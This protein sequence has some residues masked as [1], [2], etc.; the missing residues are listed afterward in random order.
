MESLKRSLRSFNW[1]LSLSGSPIFAYKRKAVNYFMKIHALLLVTVF[2]GVFVD[3]AADWAVKSNSSYTVRFM[4]FL[5]NT[6]AF[7]YHLT[8]I[9]I[10]WSIRERLVLLFKQFTNYLTKENYGQISRFTTKLFLHK[11]L[12]ILF[13]KVSYL[14]SVFFKDFDNNWTDI[15]NGMLI[16]TIYRE[17]H[18]PFVGTFSLYL[19]LL[20]V[21]HL[22]ERNM[23]ADLKWNVS[24]RSSRLVYYSIRDCIQL[25]NRVSKQV[26]ILV[27]M[28]F[29]YL[30]LHAVCSICRF[31]LVYFNGQVPTLAKTWAL[32]SIAR[33]IV[34]FSQAVFLVFITHKWTQESQEDLSSLADTIVSV[35][36]IRKWSTVLEEIKVAQEYKYRAFD[37]FNID[38][39]LLLSFVSS[40]VSLTV[41]FIQLINQGI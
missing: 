33:L 41:L 5:W 13:V 3:N 27:F 4:M 12:F 11:L 32:A 9:L 16:I 26:S 14:F 2:C 36:G 8:F 19:G 22:V 17:V 29:G 15:S 10:V 39:N 24:K 21:L 35:H 37:F 34:Y 18:D 25:K 40:F 1:D 38:R 7:G 30:F 20:K 28:M 31:Q 23:I 6:L